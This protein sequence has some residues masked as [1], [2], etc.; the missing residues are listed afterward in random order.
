[1]AQNDLQGRFL[2][3]LRDELRIEP[4]KPVLIGVSGGPDSV[5]L[6]H[7]FCWLN[8]QPDWRVPLRVAHLNHQLRGT[9][10]DEDA[11][12]VADLCDSLRIPCDIGTADV[13]T[14]ARQAGLSNEHAGRQCRFEFFERLC[15]KHAIHTV[16]LAHHADD[17]A[18]TILH[19]II[20]GTGIRGLAGIRPTRKLRED[21]EIRVIRPLLA[22]RR[23]HIEAYLKECGLTFRTDA[24]NHSPT[25]TRNRLRHDVL[26][27]LR[28]RFNPQIE[29]ALLRLAEQAR[30]IDAYLA[31]TGE[32]AI[33]TLIVEH[34]D[35]QLVL[36]CPPLLRKPRVIQ[37][38]LIR[39][40]I[41]LMGSPEGE[42]TYAHL[43]AVADLAAGQDGSKSLDL[44]AGLRV[45][46]RYSQL[47]LERA[48]AAPG[49]DLRCDDIRVSTAG[50]TPLPGFNLEITVQ[51][52]AADDRLIDNHI[53]H[54]AERGQFV[55]E[56][57]I[58]ADAVHPP[59][60]ARSRRAGDRFFPLGMT[61]M[62]KISDFLIDEKVQ[63][64]RR[65]RIVLLCDQLGPIW[66]V[67]LRLDERVRLTR[68][69]RQILRL[70]A[71]ST[72][73]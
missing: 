16:A 68:A 13:T 24:S 39:K 52:L 32:R 34:D 40:A 3:T 61:G 47:V 19:R 31:E 56:E 59:L 55:Y 15:L 71:K 44:P 4:D 8:Q 43:N 64:A 26:P 28:E 58:D 62:K 65:D 45:S 67:P 7:L 20:R 63:A 21:S 25:Y 36:H 2:A 30:D 12:F 22:I 17:N 29:D 46:R 5:A 27:L 9:D 70:S 69:T 14:R 23:T 6:L 10:A 50:T 1:M 66:V 72:L 48:T 38:Q 73:P 42:L 51:L 57:W 35:H 49:T 54:Q 53:A 41:L 60:I 11:R 37:T 33:N 18:E